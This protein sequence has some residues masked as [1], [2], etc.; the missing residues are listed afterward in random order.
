MVEN[1][2]EEGKGSCRGQE[3][4]TYIYNGLGRLA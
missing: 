3:V 1:K 2:A 4:L